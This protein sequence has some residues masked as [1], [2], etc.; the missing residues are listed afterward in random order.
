VTPPLLIYQQRNTETRANTRVHCT[1]PPP[2]PPNHP[3]DWIHIHTTACGTQQQHSAATRARARAR[4][5]TLVRLPHALNCSCIRASSARAAA[6]L[7]AKRKEY[8]NATLDAPACLAQT[9]D[10]LLVP[11][12]AARGTARTV[13]ANMQLLFVPLDGAYRGGV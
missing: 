2:S 9:I 7:Q 1:P 13:L 10:C 5:L 8:L 3:K 12:S 6:A 4:T 11:V